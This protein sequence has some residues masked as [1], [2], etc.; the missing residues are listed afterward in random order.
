MSKQ[1]KIKY[2]LESIRIQTER[3]NEA[4]KAGDTEEETLAQYALDRI[5]NAFNQDI[6]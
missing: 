4:R 2:Y 5:L 6:K 3:R 1:E